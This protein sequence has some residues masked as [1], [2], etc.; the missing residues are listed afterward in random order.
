MKNKK[1]LTVSRLFNAPV[2]NVWRAWT[3]PLIF[4]QWWGPKDFTCPVAEIDFQVGGKYL[5]S[6]RGS[7]GPNMPIKDFWSVGEYKEIIPMKK[8]VLTDSFSDEDGK[9][10]PATY[11]GMSKDFPL[12]TVVTITFEEKQGK[13]RVTVHHPDVPASDVENAKMGWEQS[14]DKLNEIV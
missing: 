13:T 12:E 2:E 7:A 5:N 9:V 11:Y 6:M 8:I 1:D 14:F 10:V 4:K 3:E